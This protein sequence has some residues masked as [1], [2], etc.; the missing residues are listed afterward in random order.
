MRR[1]GLT[2]AWSYEG[3]WGFANNVAFELGAAGVE[4]GQRVLVY[5]PNSPRLVATYFGLFIL[6]AVAVPI[7]M[8]S[9]PDF[10]QRVRESARSEVLVSA[11]PPPTE[12]EGIR[13]IQLGDLQVERVANRGHWQPELP[14]GDDLAEI[15]FTSGTTGS[16]K[17]V[18]LTHHN[19]TS[20]AVAASSVLDDLANFRGLS[21]LPLSHM[22]EQIALYA[23]LL[24]GAT[25]NY[26]ETLTPNAL[27]EVLRQRQVTMIPTVPQVM[28]LFYNAIEAE[29]RRQKRTRMWNFAHV[30]ARRSPMTVR[31]RLFAQ[32]HK[33]LG[34]HLEYFF[35]GGAYLPPELQ[36][37]WE[38]LG[39]KVLQGYGTTECSPVISACRPDDR[40]PGSVGPAIPGVQVKI[41][42]QDEILVKGP[43]V[44]QGYFENAEATDAAFTEDGWYRTKDL[45]YLNE[46]GLLYVRGRKDDMIVLPDGQNLYPEDIENALRRHPSVRD[47]AVFGLPRESGLQLHAVILPQPHDSGI[48][49]TAEEIAHAVRDINRTLANYQRVDS[50]QVWEDEDFPRTHTL[51]VKRAEVAKALTA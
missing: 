17:G 2:D 31:R 21:I 19:I 16:P 49:V 46:D 1:G 12:L 29:V 23:G 8:R 47:A 37:A 39:V 20:N 33:R 50:H 4:H 18:M 3:L 44:T 36:A 13:C 28:Q 42:D 51:K 7:D 30:V 9:S 15:V 25:F 40:V 6:G 22:F 45:G 34:G 26:V 11:E 27:F 41:G 10:V 24:L 5:A 48:H 35:C 43:N 38:R 14:Q 32:V